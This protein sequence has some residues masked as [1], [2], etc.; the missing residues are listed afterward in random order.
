M[1]DTA[2]NATRKNAGIEI[3]DYEIPGFKNMTKA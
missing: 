3:P 1:S 2:A